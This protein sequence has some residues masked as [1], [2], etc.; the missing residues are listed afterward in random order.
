[1]SNDYGQAA[2]FALAKLCE[3]LIREGYVRPERAT[4]LQQRASNMQH[5]RGFLTEAEL[6]KRKR[7]V[8]P[9]EVEDLLT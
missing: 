3:R 2:A 8:T 4:E 5:G 7:G 1:L 6:A 9:T